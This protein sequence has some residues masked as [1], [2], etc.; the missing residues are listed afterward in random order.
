MRFAFSFAAALALFACGGKVDE[1]VPR[2]NSTNAQANVPLD[3]DACTQACARIA[4]CTNTATHKGCIA[5]C[6]SEF[7]ESG[8]E[9][10]RACI[11]ALSCDDIQRGLT[12][13]YGP[14]GECMSR[15]SGR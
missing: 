6:R 3:G 11:A 5:S 15:A 13:D 2:S 1:S 8:T 12:M 14:L 9:I 4:T 10:Y 7:D